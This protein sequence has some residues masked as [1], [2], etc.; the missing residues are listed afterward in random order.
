MWRRRES[1]SRPKKLTAYIYKH[2]RSTGF[3][4]PA[5]R[6]TGCLAGESLCLGLHLA[7]SA[8]PHTGIYDA[9]YPTHRRETGA[10]VT[11]LLA[12]RPFSRYTRQR[13][14]ERHRWCFWHLII[15][16]GC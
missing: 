3:G 2:S 1:N 6:P 5:A 15:L 7:T 11:A 12:V 4:P 9:R 13:E 10:D 16:L 14:E 8:Q